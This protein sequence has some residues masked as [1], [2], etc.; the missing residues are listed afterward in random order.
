MKKLTSVVATLAL[1]LP[2]AVSPFAMTTTA[3]AATITPK[4]TTHAFTKASHFHPT[5]VQPKTTTTLTTIHFAADRA[6]AFVS[7]AKAKLSTKKTYTATKAITVTTGK[8]STTTYYFISAHGKA[9]GWVKAA[10]VT[11][12]IAPIATKQTPKTKLT[13]VKKATKKAAP[14]ATSSKKATSKMKAQ[15]KTIKLAKQTTFKAKP[16][17]LTVNHPKTS[18]P[19]I[20]KVTT[21]TT[22]KAVAKPTKAKK[23]A[24]R[25]IKKTTQKATSKAPK[26]AAKKHST[27]K[28]ATK[29]AAPKLAFKTPAKI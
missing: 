7:P 23:F 8:H 21:P 22:K 9:L 26:I 24:P 17:K 28:T 3:N 2:L 18:G 12:R 20:K 11:K 4:T 6:V 25:L 15:K 19:T 29:H 13:I 5:K 16:T 27:V 1:A 10:T 14:K